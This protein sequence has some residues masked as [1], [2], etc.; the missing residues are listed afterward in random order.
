MS[1]PPFCWP[2]RDG[3]YWVWHRGGGRRVMVLQGGLWSTGDGWWKGRQYLQEDGYVGVLTADLRLPPR[4]VSQMA[5]QYVK[6]MPGEQWMQ[7]FKPFFWWRQ[8]GVNPCRK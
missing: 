2:K 7:T 5:L 6:K 1:I 8:M 4:S 3:A